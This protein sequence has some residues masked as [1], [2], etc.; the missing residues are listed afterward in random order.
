MAKNSTVQRVSGNKSDVQ[1]VVEQRIQGDATI[2]IG[3][4]KARAQVEFVMLFTANLDA[5]LRTNNTLC[6]SDMRVML[7][8]LNKMAYGN[9][10]SIK[11]KSIASELSMDQSNV[12]KAWKKLQEAGIFVEDTHGNE[13][14]N[15]DLFLKGK[16][17]T[18]TEQLEP[19]AQLCHNV[20]E[21]KGVETKRPFRKFY[22]FSK[23]GKMDKEGDAIRA[24]RLAKPEHQLAAKPTRQ[25]RKKA[26]KSISPDDIQF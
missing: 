23:Q 1:K 7:A 25:K 6:M 20:L 18:V 12:S 11:Q 24:H 13:F 15:F 9:Q 17:R 4:T 19:Q 8:V 5:V 2:F 3:E 16:G 26:V 22:E 21:K 14:V 10:L